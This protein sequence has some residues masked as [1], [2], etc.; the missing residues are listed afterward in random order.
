MKRYVG[1]LLLLTLGLSASPAEASSSV[2]P[3]TTGI[4]EFLSDIVNNVAAYWNR[5]LRQPSGVLYVWPEPGRSVQTP[6]GP[7]D[8]ASALYCSLDDTIYISQRF[9]ADLMLA[10]G[11]AG[12]A[13]A[14]AHEYGH[15]LQAELGILAGGHPTWRTEL[16]ADCLAGNWMNFAYHRGIV[17]PGDVEEA[18]GTAAL[19]GDFDFRA[20]DH[21][22]TPQERV[23]AWQLGYETGDPGACD[24]YTGR[25]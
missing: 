9:A 21:H 25:G 11:D 16:Q 17:D 1:T 4:S 5:A 14:V 2:S 15:N 3:S 23:A 18:I 20:P 24:R 19:L 8:D 13:F 22:G 10:T 7:T 12:V 6:C